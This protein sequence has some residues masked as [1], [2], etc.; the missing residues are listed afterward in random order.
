MFASYLAENKS[1]LSLFALNKEYEDIISFIHST[2]KYWWTSTLN[3]IKVK[4]NVFCPIT[5]N[6]FALR[7]C[8][9]TPSN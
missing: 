4:V 9:I 7:N 8:D 5:Y 3:N 2:S 1:L 6:C